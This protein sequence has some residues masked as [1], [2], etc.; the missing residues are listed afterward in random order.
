MAGPD[1]AILPRIATGEI[2]RF[3]PGSAVSTNV[4][5]G[6]ASAILDQIAVPGDRRRFADL[7]QPLQ[8]GVQLPVPKGVFLR[9]RQALLAEVQAAKKFFAS[10]T[11]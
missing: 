5:T 7:P 10:R 11:Q 1:P 3:P 9:N 6:S 8:P 4:V 2:V